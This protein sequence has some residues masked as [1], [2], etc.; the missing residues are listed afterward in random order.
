ML[1][2]VIVVLSEVPGAFELRGGVYA[3]VSL[4]GPYLSITFT[5]IEL[6]I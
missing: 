4:S 2:E 5:E 1:I 3:S 6:L